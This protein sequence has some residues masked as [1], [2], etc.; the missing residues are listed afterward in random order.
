LFQAVTIRVRACSWHRGPAG[1]EVTYSEQRPKIGGD[2]KSTTSA[3]F[4]VAGADVSHY[5]TVS[6]AK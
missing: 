3:A 4:S 6:I 1:G 2:G 5:F